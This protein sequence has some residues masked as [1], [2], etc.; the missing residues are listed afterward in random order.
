MKEESAMAF[1]GF[2]VLS[3]EEGYNAAASWE[4][5]YEFAD[6]SGGG[7]AKV[8]GRWARCGPGEPGAVRDLNRLRAEARWDRESK[9]FV[10]SPRTS[11]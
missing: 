5:H 7:N 6:P 11:R 2:E 1:L 8:S 4:V 3:G 9:R 10:R